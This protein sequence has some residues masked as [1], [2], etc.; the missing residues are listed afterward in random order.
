MHFG[1][2]EMLLTEELL[3]KSSVNLDTDASHKL[4]PN[5]G[6]S[7]SLGDSLAGLPLAVLFSSV[8]ETEIILKQ[9]L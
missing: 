4:I 8:T 2:W 9:H 5:K 6:L 3:L 7:F 1:F